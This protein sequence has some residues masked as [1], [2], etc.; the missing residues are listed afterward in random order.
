MV[1]VFLIWFQVSDEDN[2]MNFPGTRDIQFISEATDYVN[3][4]ERAH[5][6]RE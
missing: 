4:F 5:M 3:D 2:K 1:G 6:L